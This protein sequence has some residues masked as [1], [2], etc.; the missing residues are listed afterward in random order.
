MIAN[1]PSR[2]QQTSTDPHEVAHSQESP[3][4]SDIP[5]KLRQALFV[6]RAL[7]ALERLWP[8]ISAVFLI[9]ALFLIYAWSTIPSAF[10]ASLRFVI[11][12]ALA[13]A[14]LTIVRKALLAKRPSQSDAL[15]H[16]DEASPHRHRP[17]QTLLDH[18]SGAATTPVATALWSAH[19]KIAREQAGLSIV[20]QWRSDLADR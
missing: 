3:D 15:R 19:Q 12:G 13:L 14:I 20:A 7:L 18:P 10:P 16:V 1:H 11:L 5:V 4:H 6:S 9:A 2:A 17:A 8:F